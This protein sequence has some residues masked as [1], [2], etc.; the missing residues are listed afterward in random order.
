MSFSDEQ[1]LEFHD[2]LDR[3]VENNL[4]IDQKARLVELLENS[5]EAR[6]HYV[7]FM[8]MSAS[9]KHYA[10]ELVGDDLVDD[11]F[12]SSIFDS[13]LLRFV[14]VPLSIAAIFVV[15]LLVYPESWFPNPQNQIV[16]AK[17]HETQEVLKR[18]VP[19][20]DAVAVLTKTVG[21][22]WD[23]NSAFRP[24]LGQ[25]LEPC[26]LSI[27]KGL[28]QVE[29]LQGSTAILEGPVEFKVN[30]PNE[31]SL[32]QGKLRASVPPVAR[33]F[34]IHLPKGKLIDLGTEFGLNVHS[35]GST[36]IYV[37]RGKI[38]YE[39][40][41]GAD[42]VS[43]EVNGG[44]ALFIDPYGSPNWMEMPSE[45]FL[46]TA[47]LAF[48]SM[49]HSQRRHAAW[50]DH[51]RMI[52]KRPETI[53]HYDFDNHSPWARVIKDKS[54]SESSSG[55]GAI[56]GCKW[57][58]GRWSGKGALE[59]ANKNDRVRLAIPHELSSIT[60]SAWIRLE[61]FS[62]S[63]SPIFFSEAGEHSMGWFLTKDGQV[64]LEIGTSQNSFK[65]ISA[66]AFRKE[67]LG[68]WTHVATTLDKEQKMVSHYVNGRPF[69]R[70]KLADSFILNID[71]CILGQVPKKLGKS[72]NY[73]SFNGSIDEFSL[74]HFA[75]SSQ[76]LR[77]MYEIGS[78]YELSNLFGPRIP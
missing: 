61:D 17:K 68:R 15:G 57:S 73:P 13:K 12:E 19:I 55:N 25:T 18:P 29:F 62:S 59:F 36:E 58:E 14:I 49:E 66:V 32:L 60:L 52:S 41:S 11:E 76:D 26:N 78:P 63:I 45:S 74:F 22:E 34:A 5:D 2:L 51:S 37:Y 48:R 77:D 38:I 69:S 23:E 35:G 9:L 39:G 56:V 46:G 20:V 44:E 54:N 67:K 42:Y 71:K 27:S 30:N 53:L 70:E 21:I 75:Y 16:E 65:Y 64:V 10:E 31:G 7:R 40:K 72:M 8:D 4:S 47:D 28:A 1:L 43:R 50:V 33:G 3:L 6:R 24:E